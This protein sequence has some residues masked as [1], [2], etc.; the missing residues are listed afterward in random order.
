MVSPTIRVFVNMKFNSLPSWHI[1]NA[2]QTH[3]LTPHIY[4]V[5]FN[6]GL[7]QNKGTSSISH[8]VKSRQISNVPYLKVKGIA[9]TFISCGSPFPN[10]ILMGLSTLRVRKPQHNMRIGFKSTTLRLCQPMRHFFHWFEPQGIKYLALAQDTSLGHKA[11]IQYSV[12][13]SNM[14]WFGPQNQLSQPLLA[15][16]TILPIFVSSKGY[17]R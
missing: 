2:P 9:T 17:E 1:T 10:G 16:L 14:F 7:L 3:R 15:S 5:S 11:I 8:S 6:K 12:H 13:G 4:H